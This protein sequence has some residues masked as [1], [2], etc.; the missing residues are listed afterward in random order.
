MNTTVNAAGAIGAGGVV[1]ALAP[2]GA[3]HEGIFVF[4]GDNGPD[5]STTTSI[6]NHQ[7]P[8]TTINNNH[9]QPTHHPPKKI[10]LAPS[11]SYEKNKK[12]PF[13]TIHHVFVL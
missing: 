1:V 12:R 3:G 11:P 9:Q 6:N 10:P 5:L 2:D 4:R 13:Q 8:S 7:Q